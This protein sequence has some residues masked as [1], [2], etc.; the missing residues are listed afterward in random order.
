M[1]KGEY[2]RAIADFNEAIRLEP[3]GA[4]VY[5]SRAR[6]YLYGG[7][8]A[9]AQADFK[10]AVGLDAKD[11]YTLLWLDLVERRN[12]LPSRLK[13]LSA[14]L[15]MAKWPGPV[16]RLLMGELP[17]QQ[18]LDAAEHAD[19]RIR[20]EQVCEANFY[21]GQLALLEARKHEAVRLFRL[22]AA[23]CPHTFIEWEAARAELK[24]LGI[25]P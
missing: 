6:A 4:W 8:L 13:Q 21:T 5:R 11:A 7:S 14:Q 25:E 19:P 1:A 10:Q 24:L 12:N 23:D 18:T 9:N 3:K 15:E 16:V 2:D 20:N 17:P 22:A